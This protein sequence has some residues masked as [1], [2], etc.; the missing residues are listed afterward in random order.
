MATDSPRFLADVMLGRLARWLRVLGYDTL[1]FSDLDDPALAERARAEDRILLTRDRELSRRKGLQVLL[2]TDDQIE[3]QLREVVK[4]LNL[5]THNAFSRCIQCNLILEEIDRETARP[6]VPPFVYTT[7]DHFRR[8]PQCG[9]VYWRGT[10]WARM[11][12]TLESADWHGE[13]TG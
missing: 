6:S 4:A 12:A 10:H 9:R 8:C 11:L 7:Y 3:G 2:L 5:S 13:A 1:Y